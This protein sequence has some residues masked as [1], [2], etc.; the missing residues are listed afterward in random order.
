MP[1]IV[2][3]FEYKDAATRRILSRR[4]IF[5]TELKLYIPSS[6]SPIM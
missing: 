5:Y 2:S 1:A 4:F 6:P 3:P